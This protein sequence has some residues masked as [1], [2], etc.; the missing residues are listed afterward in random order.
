MR[1]LMTGATGLI[2]KE[3]G[4]SLAARG[5]ALV[6][7]V[8]NAREASVRLPFPATCFEW[9]HAHAVPAQAMT[10]VDAIVNLAGEPVA[11]KR[12]SSEQKRLIR[13]TRILGTRRVVEAALRHGPQVTVFVQG[14]A[15]GYYGDRAEAALNAASA[16]GN[17][18]L[19]DLVDAWEAE[20]RPLAE[21]A[22]DLRATIVR[23]AAA[24]SG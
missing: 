6:C 18:F 11:G 13:D 12:W 21:R 20:L 14:S 5:D 24:R 10:G 17:G 4:K 16:K 3:L 9:D 1:V 19:A 23:T 7:L 15:T 22:P 2:G 8:R